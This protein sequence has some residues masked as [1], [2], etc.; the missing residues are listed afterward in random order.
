MTLTVLTGIFLTFDGAILMMKRNENRAIAPG[1][2][3]IPGGHV[4]SGELARPVDACLRELWEETGYLPEEIEGFALRYLAHVYSGVQVQVFFD[5]AASAKRRKPL[6]ESDE[7]SLHWIPF[8]EVLDLIMHPAMR[9]V[10]EHFLSR[11]ADTGPHF[12]AIRAAGDLF[13]ADWQPL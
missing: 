2:W 9:L 1:L 4:E 11:P 12:C 10:L 8:E 6:P 13:T 3:S 7:G 5:F